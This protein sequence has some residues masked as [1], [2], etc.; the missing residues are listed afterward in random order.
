MPTSPR[1]QRTDFSLDVLGRYM[2][3]GLD[4]AMASVSAGG[5]P[6]DRIVI[7][8]GSFGGALAEQLFVN[9]QAQVHRTLVLEAGPFVLPEHVQN[10]PL[11]GFNQPG[12]PTT[13][14]ELRA[15][16]QEGQPRAEVWGL[17]WHS[18]TRF[19][20]LAYCVGGRSVY[21]G[22]W[23]PQ[24]LD[25]EMPTAAGA[26]SRWPATVV[27]DL[28]AKYFAES[29][30]QIGTEETNDFIFGELQN[31]LRQ[32]L[33]DGIVAGNVTDAMAL[34]G[35]PDHPVLRKFPGANAQKLRQLLGDPPG[36][37]GLSTQQLR[38]LLKLEAPLAVQGQTLPGFFPFNKFS[39]VPLLMKAA[40]AAW[41]EAGNDARKR[42][43]I[44]PNCHVKRLQLQGG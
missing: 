7:G 22:G 40:R 19:F 12:S 38:D 8:G 31:A 3:N 10:L 32:A 41:S 39:S 20:G 14:A 1:A 29:A 23:S 33:Y 44:V 11:Q 2:C 37:A 35:L 18:S 43:M 34:N 4:E 24:L 36:A 15:L 42:L 5:R 17:P 16:G 30:R 9:D 25:A 21:F 27:N 13:I 26:P 28:K 6:F